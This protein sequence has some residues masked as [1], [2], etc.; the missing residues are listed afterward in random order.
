MNSWTKKSNNL[1]MCS[2]ATNSSTRINK[3]LSHG[4]TH[5]CTHMH[6]RRHTRIHTC[7]RTHVCARTHTHTHAH[8]HARTHARTH[9]DIIVFHC[10]N[11]YRVVNLLHFSDNSTT[12]RS[13]VSKQVFVPKTNLNIGKCAFSVARSCTNNLEST[14]Y[15]N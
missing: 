12:L 4:R 9:T 10:Q 8:K 7:M 5:A 13:S 15:Y 2:S 14:S 6:T 1:W 3:G 11:T